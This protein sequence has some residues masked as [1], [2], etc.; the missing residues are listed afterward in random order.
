VEYKALNFK[1]DDVNTGARTFTGYA[2]T[3]DADLGNDIISKGAFNKTLKERGDRVKILW[4][5]ADPIGKP[6]SM[7]TDSKGLFV[8]GKISKTRLG[9]EA[10]EL[11]NDG[12]IDQMSIGFSIPSGKSERDSKGMRL[13]NEVKLFEFSLVTFPMNENA[14]VT[15]I[16][17]VKAAIQSGTYDHTELKELADALAELN[18]LLKSEPPKSTQHG[19]QPQEL[20]ALQ[21]ALKNFGL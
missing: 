21:K 12:V 11:M 1:A 15:S 16:K 20:D 14:F 4:Q 10:V 5:H 13:I 9:D 8:E 6:L 3:F 7:N 19:T 2:S 18:A 17:S